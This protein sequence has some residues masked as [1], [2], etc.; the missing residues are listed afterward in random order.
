VSS[1]DNFLRGPE[2]LAPVE[3]SCT[4]C[5][6]TRKF[7]SHPGTA[8]SCWGD[9]EEKHPEEVMTQVNNLSPSDRDANGRDVS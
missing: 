6:N 2:S 9:K 7:A 4:Q 5:S 8:P 1:F 3:F